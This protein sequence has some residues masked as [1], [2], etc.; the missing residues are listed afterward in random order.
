[1]QVA[2][3]RYAQ[4]VLQVNLPGGR[5]EKICA[6]HDIRDALRGIVD[7]HG[8]LIGEQSVGPIEDEVADFATQQL[9][10]LA[11]NPVNEAQFIRPGLYT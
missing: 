8:E 4:Q 9:R 7:D 10:L 3:R 5:V 11:L 2:G 1:V 6:A